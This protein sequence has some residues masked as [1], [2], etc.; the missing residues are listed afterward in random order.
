MRR[1]FLIGAVS[2]LSLSAFG[3]PEPFFLGTYTHSSTS[4]G[5]YRGSFDPD[6][7]KLGPLELAAKA[8]DPGFL[9]LS[10]DGRFLYAGR[11]GNAQDSSVIAYAVGADGNLTLINQQ[12]SGGA[13]TC[14][15]SLDTTG[16]ILFAANY[17]SGSIAC[18]P[19]GTDGSLAPAS[20][21][22]QFHGSGP[23]KGRQ[24]GPHAHSIYVSPDNQFVYSC[25]LG[26]DCIWI[27]RFD[28]AKG[29]LTPASPAFGLVPP[30]SG[31]RHLVFGPGG[32]IVYVVNEMGSAV[33]AFAR[34]AKSGAL[35]P[36]E[37]V[38][39]L[40]TGVPAGPKITSAEIALHPSGRWLYV[41]VRGPDTVAVFSIDVTGRLRPIQRISADVKMP[42]Q[43]AI[44]PSGRWLIAAG[45]A[46]N[47][48]A[49]LKIDS[50]TGRL[51]STGESASIGAPV[52][53]LF[54]PAM[55]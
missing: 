33:T 37:T 38:S 12:P 53:V 47:R 29:T 30:G 43:F 31:P 54:A 35:M 48:L 10:S 52:C 25:D 7:G 24:A 18:F 8:V 39:C 11:E 27:F 20:C 41:S 46:D 26:S 2:L 21:T 6:T 5:I 44:D 22:V 45:Q 15:V 17:S 14:H 42:R 16:R 55:H 36:L 51:S 28:A 23:N 40:P 3:A 1:L 32:R 4:Q 9:A 34:N 49:V 19:I 13:G 50:N